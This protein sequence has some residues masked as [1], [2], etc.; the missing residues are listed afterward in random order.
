MIEIIT[1]NGVS[2]DLDPEGTFEI[3]M[4]QPL[5]DTEAVPVP[6]STGRRSQ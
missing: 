5:L 2:L 1:I 6:Y 3:E 4:E